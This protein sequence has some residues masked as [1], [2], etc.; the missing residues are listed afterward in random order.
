VNVI[1]SSII[2][3]LSNLLYLL[4]SSDVFLIHIFKT[5]YKY[6]QRYHYKF[7][8][9]AKDEPQINQFQIRSSRESSCNLI[10][11]ACQ[12]QHRSEANHDSVGEVLYIEEKA[13]VRYYN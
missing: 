11:K 2:N 3:H 9:N 10:K 6:K 5:I 12:Y 7:C 4:D 13:Q 8:D 1:V